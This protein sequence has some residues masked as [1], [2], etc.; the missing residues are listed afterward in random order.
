MPSAHRGKRIACTVRLPFDEYREVVLRAQ[1]RRWSISDYIGYC[2]EREI[3][4]RPVEARTP[5]GA[6]PALFRNFDDSQDA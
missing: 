3:I 2:V 4:G 1:K 5:T 6:D